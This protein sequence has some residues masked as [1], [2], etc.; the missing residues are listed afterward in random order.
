MCSNTN[1]V[2]VETYNLRKTIAI[3]YMCSNTNTVSM[4]A[5]N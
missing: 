5:Y 4:A 1:T 3:R 2:F